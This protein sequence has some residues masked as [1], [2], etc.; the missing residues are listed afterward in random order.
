MSLVEFIDADWACFI[1]NGWGLEIFADTAKKCLSFDLT[2]NESY[3][4][5]KEFVETKMKLDW[6]W[7]QYNHQEYLL[8]TTPS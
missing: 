4:I 3:A 5:N 2:F 7:R 6:T 8:S 1:G